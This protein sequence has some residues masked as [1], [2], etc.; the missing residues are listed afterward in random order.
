MRNATATLVLAL[1][2][3]S[4]SACERPRSVDTWHLTTQGVLLLKAGERKP[5]LIALPDWV[6]AG[7]P[8]GCGPALAVGPAG[9]AVITSDVVP[10]LWR[11]DPHSLRVT[12]HSLELVRDADKDFG[13]SALAYSSEQAAFIGVSGMQGSVWK[14]DARLTK[15][16]RFG[17]PDG[18]AARMQALKG[19]PQACV[20]QYVGF[21]LDN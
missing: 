12:L 5:V 14:I 11:V 15:A 18:Q 9:E 10:T 1:T 2:L 8:Y 19:R 3:A 21:S 6:W 17:R 13:F 4:L 16:E 7:D 20:T